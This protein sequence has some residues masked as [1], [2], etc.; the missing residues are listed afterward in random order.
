MEEIIKGADIEIWRPN[1]QIDLN[2]DVIDADYCQDV[3]E[4]ANKSK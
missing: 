4:D 3:D 1:R 2:L